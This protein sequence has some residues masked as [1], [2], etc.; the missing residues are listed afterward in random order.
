MD[1]RTG[2]AVVGCGYWGVNYVRVFT[3]LPEAVVLWACDS[4]PRR[5]NGIQQRFPTVG[6]TADIH[7]VLQDPNVTAVVVATPATTHFEVTRQCL[8]RGKHVLVEK[9]LTTTVEDGEGLVAL[10]RQHDQVLMVG[11]TFLYNAGLQKMKA[12]IDSPAFGQ[13]YYLRSTRTN[14]G[15][16]RHDVNALWDL[17]PH[18]VA[19]FN[20]LLDAE[21]EAVWATGSSVLR[22]DKEDVG[23][24]HLRYPNDVVGTI[25][26]SWVEPHKVREVVVVGSQQRVVFDDVSPQ[27]KIR[28][29]EKGVSPSETEVDSYGEYQLLIRDGDIISPRVQPSEPLKN[30]C[31][32]FLECARDGKS[33]RT[34][35]GDGLAVVRVMCAVDLSLRQGGAHISL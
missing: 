13:V 6:L 27:E 23:Y 5:L 12:C 30:Q 17:A 10:D 3:E 24:I 25:H 14:L 29:W 9:P 8:E 20:Y 11:H 21:P 22:G 16:I 15:P 34:D 2:V 32:H 26:V 4:D 33:P 31:R 18:D 19:I 28:I 1:G 35:A 7:V